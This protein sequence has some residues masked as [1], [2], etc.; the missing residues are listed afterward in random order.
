MG[1]FGMLL[2]TATL[3]AANLLLGKRL[4]AL[5]GGIKKD[6]VVT[7]LL[8]QRTHRVAIYGWHQLNG[9]PIQPVF[10]GHINSYVDY[11]HGIRWINKDM[12]VDSVVM[13][14][15]QVL[16]NPTLYKI[17]SNESGVMSQ[18]SYLKNNFPPAVPK[19]FGVRTESGNSLRIIVQ[20]DSTV[21]GYVILVS[22]DGVS[23]TDSLVTTPNNLVLTNLLRDSLYFVKMVAFNQI[24]S[25]VPSEVLA[26]VPA[27]VQPQ[28]L[29]VNGFDHASAGNTHDF[30]RQHGSAFM[31]NRV[32]LSSATNDAIVDGLFSL[33]DY[34]VVDYILGDESYV[35]ETFSAAEQV[36]VKTF[37]QNGG[38]LFVSGSELAWDLG[39]KGTPSD[40]DFLN[41]FLKVKYI[42]DAPDGSPG[43]TYQAE[44]I[45]GT[46]FGGFP[47]ISFDNGTHGTID[48]QWPDVISPMP[49]AVGIAKYANL[50]T[51]SGYSGVSYQ[52]YF[53]SGTRP[54]MSIVL[55]F[56][57]E[58]VYPQSL[59][60]QLLS[61]VLNFFGTI[62]AVG[63]AET[64]PTA[65]ALYQNFPN[66]FNPSTT[67]RYDLPSDAFVVLRIFNTL[68][69]GIDKLIDAR[70]SAGH[71]SVSW[72]SN[73][74]PSGVY[75]YR[76]EAD[77]RLETKRMLVLK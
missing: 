36:K 33:T 31:A 55:G 74:I 14:A 76:L 50:D 62:S 9:V 54:G 18:P 13:S 30:I 64:I 34:T 72:S 57:F 24:G 56:P 37:L 32:S 45:S 28:A 60:T 22:K 77:S 52:G 38:K 8:Q 65:F 67:I 27:V 19:S 5:V 12:L 43:S 51:S 61:R 41:N 39:F 26:G 3:L 35:D 44:G 73:H 6:V 47:N 49:G 48:V 66:P 4:G 46:L 75:F 29:I 68:G 71:H 63:H 21:T 15:S 17:L 42:N 58:T 70:Q 59:R 1:V 40:K 23:F 7:N 20:P 11:S 16:T 2:L 25:S 10:S 53:P 69:Q